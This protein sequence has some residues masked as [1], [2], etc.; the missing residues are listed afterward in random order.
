MFCDLLGCG[1]TALF[2]GSY[3]V[4][5]ELPLPLLQTC[6]AAVGTG[7]G[8]AMQANPIV[9][10]NLLGLA[11]AGHKALR[12]WRAARAGRAGRAP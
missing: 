2:L 7:Y 3:F 12:V 11:S 4:R 5:G 9:V 8:L 1:A 6:S 10:S